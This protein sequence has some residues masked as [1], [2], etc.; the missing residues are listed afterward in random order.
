MISKDLTSGEL[1]IRWIWTQSRR[2]R[3]QLHH[4]HDSLM[5]N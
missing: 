1:Q 3:L 5:P 4:Q 2:T